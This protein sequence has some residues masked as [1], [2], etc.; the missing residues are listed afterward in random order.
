V[1]NVEA[2]SGNEMDLIK[3]FEKALYDERANLNGLRASLANINN[4]L[5]LASA[6]KTTYTTD[7]KEILELRKQINEQEAIYVKNGSNDEAM[8]AKLKELRSR[9]VKLNSSAAATPGKTIT[10]E[11]LLQRQGNTEAEITAAEQN[12]AN[13]ET[14]IYRLRGS[15]GSYAGKEATVSSLQKEIDLATEEY[16]ALKEK[17]NA[18]MQNRN[19]VTHDNFKITMKGQPAIKPESGKRLIIMGLSGIAVFMLMSFSILFMEFIDSSLKSPSIFERMVDLKLISTI[20]HADLRKYSILE[21]L[22][23]RITDKNDVTHRENTFREL[24]RKLRFAVEN[25]GKKIFLLTSTEPGQGKTTL[26]QALAYSLSLSNKK[27]LIIDTNFCNNDLTV[28]LQAK[29]TL[30][31]FSIPRE[32]F[33]IDKIRDIVTTYE[34]DG[35]EV[36]GCKGGDYTPSEILPKN[37]LLNYL[38]ELTSFYDFILLEG[39]PLNDYTD[40]K[41]LA[42]YVDGVIAIFSANTSIKQ[43]DKESIAFL[44][45]LGDK[46]TG[47]VLNGVRED[48]LEL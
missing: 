31:T 15:L 26:T 37:H 24:L 8:A 4:Q 13:L 40:S 14:K 27:V 18:A 5:N 7:N 12:A 45:E 21:V 39:A 3:Q 47:A 19:V 29:E 16:T 35:V 30:E 17:L 6:G 28:Q 11:E 22:Q 25:S 36:I 32:E 42:Q 33:G 9:L 44:H 48:Y 10:R 43:I 38:Q 41:E 2:A 1:L 23:N 20:N 46:F 34:T